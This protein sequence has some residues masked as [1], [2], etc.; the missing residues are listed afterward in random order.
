MQDAVTAQRL[1]DQPRGV[2]GAAGVGGDGV[3]YGALLPEQAR[4]R[5]GQ[6]ACA[7]VGDEH[8]GDDVAGELWGADAFGAA[9]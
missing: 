5:V 7:V 9:G 3:L 1:G 2:V 6:P 8:G 4:E